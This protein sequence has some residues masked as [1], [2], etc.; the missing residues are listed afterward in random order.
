MLGNI[1]D[2]RRRRHQRMRWFDS[3]TDSMDMN[4]SKLQE[5]VKEKE[6]WCSS[7]RGC[8]ELNVT[9]QLNNSNKTKNRSDQPVSRSHMLH[10]VSWRRLCQVLG[11]GCQEAS[12]FGGGDL[13]TGELDRG[14]GSFSHQWGFFPQVPQL[15]EISP[16]VHGDTQPTSNM[17]WRDSASKW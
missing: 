2:K 3:I 8:K 14:I 12:A 16:H 7:P 11:H 13:E 1:E 4:L 10:S 9:Q 6:A 5:I 17:S 15:M